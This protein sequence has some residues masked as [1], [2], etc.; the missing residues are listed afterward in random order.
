M[1]Y[2]CFVMI[3]FYCCFV[4]IFC[5]F[6]DC[7]ILLSLLSFCIFLQNLCSSELI[8][9]GNKERL[10]QLVPPTH[11]RVYLAL[12]NRQLMQ[13]IAACPPHGCFGRHYLA[14]LH[15][16]CHLSY[17]KHFVKIRFWQTVVK[18]SYMTHSQMLGKFEYTR[19]PIFKVVLE[20]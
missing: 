10:R 8:K 4:I 14:L 19:G 15:S 12:Q 5:C 9:D 18:L 13:N 6:V 11:R 17:L 3:V 2:C 16:R 7:F 20:C 1:S